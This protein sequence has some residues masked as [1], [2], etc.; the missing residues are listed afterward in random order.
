MC[1]CSKCSC[2]PG[3]LPNQT[4]DISQTILSCANLVDS[5]SRIETDHRQQ[6]TPL[7]FLPCKARWV[8]VV[9]RGNRETFASTR[10]ASCK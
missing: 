4:S 1:H 3:W 10:R 6:S 9:D 2:L 7:V 8:A 5:K